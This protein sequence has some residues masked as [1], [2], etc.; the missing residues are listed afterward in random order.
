MN[1]NGR[2]VGNT[3]QLSAENL[4]AIASYIKSLPPIEGPAPPRNNRILL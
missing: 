4:A 1:L 3:S 2:L